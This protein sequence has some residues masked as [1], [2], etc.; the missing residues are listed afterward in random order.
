MSH[1]EYTKQIVNFA[2]IPVRTVVEIAKAGH[3]RR[4]VCVGLNADAGVV[5]DAEEIVHDFEAGVA[6]WVIDGCDVAYLSELGGRV[7]AGRVGGSLVV[8]KV[9]LIRLV[10]S[11]DFPTLSSPQMEMRTGGLLGFCPPMM[12]GLR[13]MLV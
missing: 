9:S 2:L 1:E 13:M 11:A 6:S 7:I 5:S 12:F 4:L 8:T 3:G 10:M